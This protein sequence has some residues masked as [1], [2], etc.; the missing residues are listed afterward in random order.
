MIFDYVRRT[1]IQEHT[2]KPGNL[3]L[4][5]NQTRHLHSLQYFHIYVYSSTS[6]C[7]KMSVQNN[8]K[9]TAISQ[10]VYSNKPKFTAMSQTVQQLVQVYS[11]E[12][13]ST[14]YIDEW[15]EHQWVTMY[16][17][18]TNC[19]A[20]SQIVQQEVKCKLN[21]INSHVQRWDK[22]YNINSK[23]YSDESSC[24]TWAKMNSNTSKFTAI[25]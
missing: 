13:K 9:C 3:G 12:P 7:T 25:S 1:V 8:S 18:Q 11:D 17:N 15:S 19:K 14:P 6:K 5:L 20:L 16:S 24:T 4:N 2:S 21:N 10:Y 22:V 23:V